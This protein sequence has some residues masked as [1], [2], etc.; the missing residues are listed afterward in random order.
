MVGRAARMRLSLLTPPS[1][2][3]T[4]R[5]SRITTVLPARSTSCIFLIGICA[6]RSVE[7]LY[8]NKRP[9]ARDVVISA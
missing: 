3:G 2:M 1:F 7:I 8:K 6:L 9:A 4:L 5:S